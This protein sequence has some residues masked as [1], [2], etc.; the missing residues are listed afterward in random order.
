MDN[1]HNCGDCPENRGMD[2]PLP[3]GQPHCWVDLY[4]ARL[5]NFDSASE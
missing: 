1:S 5:E 3:C 4:C 2:D